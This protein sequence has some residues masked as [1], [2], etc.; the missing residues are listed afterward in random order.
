MTVGRAETVW[1]GSCMVGLTFEEMEFGLRYRTLD[2]E[3]LAGQDPLGLQRQR[4]KEQR[5][6]RRMDLL[7]PRLAS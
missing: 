5:V 3:V 1:I 4:S 6:I 7:L 2:V